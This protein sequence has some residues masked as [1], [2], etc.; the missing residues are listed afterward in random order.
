M[1]ERSG[2]GDDRGAAL[3]AAARAAFG[4]LS[5]AEEL[6]LLAAAIGEPREFPRGPEPSTP[7]SEWPKERLVRAA[8]FRWLV[9]DGGATFVHPRGIA[10]GGVAVEDDLD[11]ADARQQGCLYLKRC[12]LK[13]LSIERAE[14]GLLSFSN[15]TVRGTLNVDRATIRGGV[16]LTEGF[17]AEGEVRLLGAE[18]GG[19][20]VCNGAQFSN[21][22]GN[23]LS[24]DQATIRGGVFLTEG[25][26]AEGEVRLLGAEIGGQ[27]ACQ[28]A[29]IS[30]P[31]G[32]ALSFD[33]ATIRG[34]VFLKD[35]FRAEGQ[36]R[37]LGAEIGGELALNSA[38]LSNPKGDALSADEATIH[39]GIFLRDGFRAEGHVR[40]LGAKIGGQLSCEGAQ[41]NN[42]ESNALSAD[43]ATIRGGVFLTEGFRAEGE[44]RLLGAEIGG[45]LVCNGAQFSNPEGDALNV[46][47]ATIRSGVFLTEGF[48]AEGE[49]RLLGAE[50]G[51]QLLCTG[52]QFSN[53]EGD[54][55]NLDHATIRSVVH[56]TDGFRA[57]GEVRL[58]GAEIG[59]QLACIGAQLRNPKG[60]AL[61]A[62]GA[63]IH[64]GVALSAS[65]SGRVSFFGAR[66]AEA[67]FL[68]GEWDDGSV[69]DLE[70][71]HVDVLWD[72][73]FEWSKVRPA[74]SGFEYGAL[75][76][77]PQNPH[78][79]EPRLQWL[80][81][82]VRQVPAP[83]TLQFDPKPYRQL[84]R[85][86]AAAGHDELARRV[87]IRREWER[88]RHT[89]TGPSARCAGFLF[90][91]FLGFG[92][93][94]FRALGLLFAILVV[95]T[96]LYATV[97]AFVPS[98]ASSGN[99]SGATVPAVSKGS[100]QKAASGAIHAR[101]LPVTDAIGY[102]ID[103]LPAIDLGEH[104][105]WTIAPSWRALRVAT[106]LE[107]IFAWILVP[108]F[109]A[110]ATGLIRRRE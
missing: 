31:E 85:V 56:L 28:G 22:K 89:A 68:C 11:L 48:R 72:N 81:K 108:L 69:F 39:G 26:R 109:A 54:A 32:N 67:L 7:P 64:G 78:D 4:G 14:L 95:Y 52:A 44:V 10:I 21:P 103:T 33:L 9:T 17:R 23:A 41:L 50:I 94:P 24:A 18:I 1:D 80:A 45:Q 8:F 74:L 101:R 66:I 13:G 83:P 34:S 77:L 92:Y 63:T 88:L 71:A 79:L 62:D 76:K 40:L 51:G 60:D 87:A 70:H 91:L 58:L 55:L 36:V 102:S 43:G 99:A 97:P 75:A 47:H 35:G 12:A 6:V 61:S 82:N 38:Q 96:A 59:G 84:E 86:L 25:F 3:R 107:V 98:K 65:I 73:S 105:S 49:V 27:L 19:Q 20:L 16:F 5:E 2:S 57:E 90:G 104:D 106:W 100:V 37:L 15:S 29:Q 30:N 42:P 110:A 93:R 46:D 53:P